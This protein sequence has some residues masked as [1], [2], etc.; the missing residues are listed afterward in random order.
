MTK[1]IKRK[2]VS[3]RE[4]LTRENLIKI[5]KVNGTK[6]VVLNPNSKIF[7]RSAY[8]CYNESCVKDA[9]KK[10]KLEKSLKAPISEEIKAEIRKITLT[11]NGEI[12]EY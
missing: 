3:C 8:L 2:C 7:G 1:D 6:D 12:D 9:F 11:K 4:E 5:T 10:N